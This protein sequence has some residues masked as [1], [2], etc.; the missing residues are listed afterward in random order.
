MEGGDGEAEQVRVHDG[1]D[2]LALLTGVVE[3]LIDQVSL[4]G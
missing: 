4:D 1:D 3:V 2:L